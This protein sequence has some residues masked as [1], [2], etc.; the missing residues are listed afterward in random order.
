MKVMD[1]KAERLLHWYDQNKRSLPWRENPTPY[2]TWVSEIM[3]QQT[4]V[5]AVKE[6]YLRFMKELPDNK[7]LAEATED[8][9]MKLWE[10]LGYYS[11]VRNLHKAAVVIEEN[12]GGKMP[13][14]AAELRTLPG[15]GPYTSAAIAAIAF[16]ECLPALD[17]NLLRI[18]SRMCAYGENIK[19]DA[20]KAAAEHFY[21]EMMRGDDAICED[22]HICREEAVSKGNCTA[23][24]ND[25][26]TESLYADVKEITSEEYKS[27]ESQAE[28]ATFVKERKAIG[29]RAGDFNQALMDLGA[30]VCL[31]NS[32]P[33][34]EK[35]P[36]AEF[37]RAHA[38]GRE[39]DF[40]VMP[41]KKARKIEE[42]T[43]FLIHYE[44]KIALRKR[45][46]KGLLAGLYE[47]PNTAGHLEEDVALQYVEGLGFHPLRI[48]R[49]REGKHIFTHKEWHMIGYEIYADE[50]SEAP[51]SKSK[52]EVFLATA[53]EIAEQYSV[54]SAFSVYKS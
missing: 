16:G 2:Q 49:L 25:S 24:V 19:A 46:A 21:L 11:R 45:P 22:R 34:C 8:R 54:P 4:R 10:G 42:L 9:Y 27:E 30:S 36:W 6:Y 50:L 32:T 39:M 20:A 53:E 13:E 47:F 14:S 40:P 51:A 1:R 37:C 26:V 35:C 52:E 38:C 3:L 48:R 17:G 41:E 29:K 7:A 28:Q 33:L 15:I 43:V 31:P 18:F 12:Y 44:G 23:G 5:E